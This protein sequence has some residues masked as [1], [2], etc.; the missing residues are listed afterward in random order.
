MTEE[1]FDREIRGTRVPSNRKKLH[2]HE[3]KV[4]KMMRNLFSDGVT[5]NQI[6]EKFNDKTGDYASGIRR[7]ISQC[8]GMD[9]LQCTTAGLK[10]MDGTELLATAK[11]PV[12]FLRDPWILERVDDVLKNDGYL[13]CLKTPLSQSRGLYPYRDEDDDD[14]F[15]TIPKSDFAI[16][17]TEYCRWQLHQHVMNE[18]RADTNRDADYEPVCNWNCTDEEC[19]PRDVF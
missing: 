4:L 12:Y 6:V 1:I 11:E 15:I 5:T 17:Y 8:V 18:R 3:L 2:P 13:A 7:G 14:F 9:L 16:I 19:L 10:R